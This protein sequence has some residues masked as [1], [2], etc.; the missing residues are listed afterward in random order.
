MDGDGLFAERILNGLHVRG[1]VGIFLV[2]A[3]DD[4]NRRLR[5][6]F[7]MVDRKSVV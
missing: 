4:E 6:L 3:I 5:R 7:H 1:K 2:E